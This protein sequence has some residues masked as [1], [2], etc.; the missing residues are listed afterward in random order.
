MNQPYESI[1]IISDFKDI[2]NTDYV[3]DPIQALSMA[4][5]VF[6]NKLEKICCDRVYRYLVYVPS[7]NGQMKLLFKCEE[8]YDGCACCK[9]NSNEAN[10]VYISIRYI[11][12]PNN[13]DD[14]YSSPFVEVKQPFVFKCC[15]K[16]EIFVSFGVNKQPIGKISLHSK[17]FD[18]GFWIFDDTQ[19]KKYIIKKIH[20][21]GCKRAYIF[22]IYKTEN[23]DF[24]V[25]SISYEKNTF[26]K[27]ENY[28][29]T[30]PVDS[31]PNDKINLISFSL[32]IYHLYFSDD[33]SSTN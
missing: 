31:S 30:F 11:S 10:I 18:R 26:G 8:K 28:Q 29:I 23:L 17:C 6:I 21:C 7:P 25:G 1:P 27:N 14:N 9:S 19:N 20:K 5:N 33:D 15:G 16:P 12:S 32:L 22:N 2:G 24:P 4:N 13:T 3:T